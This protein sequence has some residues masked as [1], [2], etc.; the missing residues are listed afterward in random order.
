MTKGCWM[1]YI[2]IINNAII[3]NQSK[4]KMTQIINLL[5]INGIN[6]TGSFSTLPELIQDAVNRVNLIGF[7]RW[8]K[9]T[10]FGVKVKGIVKQLTAC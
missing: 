6:A 3:H 5:E 4:S 7:D 8:E 1:L 2:C 10:T 9:E